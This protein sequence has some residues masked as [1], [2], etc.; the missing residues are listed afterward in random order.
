MMYQEEDAYRQLEYVKRK[1]QDHVCGGK[2]AYT[3]K[4]GKK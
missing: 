4:M 2:E 3:E 1:N